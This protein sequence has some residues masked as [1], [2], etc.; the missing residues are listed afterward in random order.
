MEKMNRTT[1]VATRESRETKIGLE[2]G[3]FPGPSS[4]ATGVG[5]L[6]HL[7]SSLSCH[8]GWSLNLNCKGDIEIDDHHSIEDC[9]I[10]LG[11]ALREAIAANGSIRRFGCAYAPMDEALARA[12]V[13]ISGRPFGDINLGLGREMIG[14]LAAENAGH[15]LSSLAANAGITLH[16][17]VLKG[18]NDHH[19]AEAA[20]KA[21]ALALREALSPPESGAAGKGDVASTKGATMLRV[22]KKEVPGK[23]NEA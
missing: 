4:I 11:A 19:K 2:L 17:D 8:A 3:L 18:S 21:L 15:F 12:V 13:D 20:F 10:T 22:T 6:D 1:F 5:F 16:V 14:D 7:L 9:A 23:G